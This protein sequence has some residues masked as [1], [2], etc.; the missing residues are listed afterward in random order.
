MASNLKPPVTLRLATTFDQRH[1]S[2]Q[3]PSNKSNR[4]QPLDDHF[5]KTPFTQGWQSLRDHWAMKKMARSLNDLSKSAQGSHTETTF[6]LLLRD[7]A[8]FDRSMVAQRSPS[9]VKGVLHGGSYCSNYNLLLAILIIRRS[10]T[11][12]DHFAPNGA[13]CDQLLTFVVCGRKQ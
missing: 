6:S 9:C 8:F 3:L 4:C 7:R 11:I 5:G 12:E 1:T 13:L 2:Q 10:V